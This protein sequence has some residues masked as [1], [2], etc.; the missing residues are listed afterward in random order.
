[1]KNSTQA[2]WVAAC[3]FVFLEWVFSLTGSPNLMYLFAGLTLFMEALI[4]WHHRRL[5]FPRL[6]RRFRLFFN[7]KGNHV[8]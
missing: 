3:I 5:L 8:H 6:Y 4:I 2:L 1:M 7:L